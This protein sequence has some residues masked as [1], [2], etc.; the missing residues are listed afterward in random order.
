M[1]PLSSEP[2]APLEIRDDRASVEAPSGSLLTSPGIQSSKAACKEGDNVSGAKELHGK[3]G[4]EA[5]N[6][7]CCSSETYW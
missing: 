1:A 7:C 5:L 6:P 2:T 3:T 4:T